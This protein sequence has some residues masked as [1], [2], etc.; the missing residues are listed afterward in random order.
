MFKVFSSVLALPQ[1]EQDILSQ[2]AKAPFFRDALT[3]K[4]SQQQL[5][6]SQLQYAIF[7]Y[8]P[9]WVNQLMNLRNKIVKLFGFDVGQNN[10]RPEKAELDVGDQAGFLTISEKHDNEIIS[11]AEDKHMSF[12]ISVKKQKRCRYSLYLSEPK[13][14][15]W[16]DLRQCHSAVSLCHSP[17][18]DL[19]RHQ[20]QK[21]MSKSLKNNKLDWLTFALKVLIDKGPETLKIAK[22]CDLKGVT[23]GS[24]YHHFN[25]RAEFVESLMSHWYETTTI[26]FI[27]Q[28]NTEDNALERL[29]KLDR[30]IASNNV[31]AEL[32][33]R[34]WALKEPVISKHLAKIDTQRRDYLAHCYHELG[35]SQEKAR[36]VALLAYAN[37]LGMQQVQPTPSIEDSLRVSAMAA[38]AFLPIPEQ[39]HSKT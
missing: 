13:N 7:N 39:N 21:N 25:N 6:P 12:Y 27:E 20:S 19:Q 15:N 33:I 8:M 18:S 22:L 24:F 30:V 5:T 28:A 10:M 17:S 2:K 23:K 36:D 14:L 35:L 31:E 11:H 26:A 38:R 37:F 29:Q 34:A 16:K 1:P 32:H 9:N 4:I 3:A